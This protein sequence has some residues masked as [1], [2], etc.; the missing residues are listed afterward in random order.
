MEIIALIYIEWECFWFDLHRIE[1]RH[2][3][4]GNMVADAL[5]ELKLAVVLAQYGHWKL[6]PTI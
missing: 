4:I 1:H 3:S 5:V 2:E 6:Q